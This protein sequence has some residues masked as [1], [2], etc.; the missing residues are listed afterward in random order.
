MVLSTFELKSRTVKVDFSGLVLTTFPS[1]RPSVPI[2]SPVFSWASNQVEI[3][4][5]SMETHKKLT[6]LCA[7]VTL[8]YRNVR[9][10]VNNRPQHSNGQAATGMFGPPHRT[11][12]Y[13]LDRRRNAGHRLLS[14]GTRWPR[15]RTVRGKM[16]A[17][18]RATVR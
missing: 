2:L 14:G 1:Q 9:A 4:N 16:P 7:I 10:A 12:N 15:M 18:S 8:P 11:I 17:I 3:R 13:L 5:T 6:R